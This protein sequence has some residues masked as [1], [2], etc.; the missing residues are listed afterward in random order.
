[1]KMYQETKNSL[2]E[3][4]SNVNAAE[5]RTGEPK[6]R[7]TKSMQAEAPRKKGKKREQ[8]N[9]ELWYNTKRCNTRITEDQKKEMVPKT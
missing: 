1:M 5:K 6:P 7:L 8:R 3:L 9:Q 2:D 4:Q